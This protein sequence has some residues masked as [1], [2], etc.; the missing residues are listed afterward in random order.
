MDI[1]AKLRRQQIKMRLARRKFM[2]AKANNEAEITLTILHARWSQLNFICNLWA[3]AVD[4]LK[5][6]KK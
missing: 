6:E 1:E 2:K 5:K 4:M 3:E